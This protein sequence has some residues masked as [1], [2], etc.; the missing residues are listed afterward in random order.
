MKRYAAREV[1]TNV[2]EKKVW[3]TVW[4]FAP[5][6]VH[7]RTCGSTV[8]APCSRVAARHR[9]DDVAQLVRR[10]EVRSIVYVC[11]VCVCVCVWCVVLWWRRRV[12]YD[13][14]V[15]NTVRHNTD[16]GIT[17]LRYGKTQDSS[18]RDYGIVEYTLTGRYTR[19]R[20]AALE[21]LFEYTVQSLSSS[22][23]LLLLFVSLPLTHT[24]ACINGLTRLHSQAFAICDH[25]FFLFCSSMKQYW[26]G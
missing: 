19:C 6:R 1:N 24:I 23:I 17:R 26:T 10:K 14:W 15:H 3:S 25:R 7:D 22:I 16:E 2:R 13:M 9:F 8:S 20:A 18:T 11:S 4:L 5:F 12:W 21:I